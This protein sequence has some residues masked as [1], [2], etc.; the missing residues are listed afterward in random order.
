MIAKVKKCYP[1]AKKAFIFQAFRPGWGWES[2]TD[3]GKSDIPLT[4]SRLK[5]LKLF[6]YTGVSLM[7]KDADGYYL[8]QASDYSLKEFGL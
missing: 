3:A 5:D 4:R 6:G 2:L 8:A 7:I 1:L